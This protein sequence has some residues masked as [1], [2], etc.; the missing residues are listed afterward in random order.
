SAAS[1][2]FCVSC[3]ESAVLV[4][5]CFRSVTSVRT[6]ATSCCCWLA[7]A[8][9]ASAFAAVTAAGLGFLDVGVALVWAQAQAAKSASARA[10][11]NN[12]LIVFM[13]F[14][15]FPLLGFVL[16]LCFSRNERNFV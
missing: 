7:C 5:F 15:S 4:A 9:A 16:N 8:C 13:E 12:F 10:V 11:K 6:A 14:Q 3:S 1:T 2:S